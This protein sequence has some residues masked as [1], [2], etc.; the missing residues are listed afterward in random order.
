MP[1]RPAHIPHNIERSALQKLISIGKLPLVK[2]HP[3]GKRTIELMIAKGWI[4]KDGQEYS[5]TEAGEAAL[6]AKIPTDR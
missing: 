4:R 2:L 6:R 1:A 5:L 3:A